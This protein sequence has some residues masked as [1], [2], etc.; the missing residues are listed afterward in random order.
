VTDWFT[1]SLRAAGVDPP[2]DRVI[3]GVGQLEWLGGEADA[4]AREGYVCWIGPEIYGVKWRN[5]KLVLVAQMCTLDAASK[6]PTPR[7]INLTTD[8][9]EREAVSPPYLHT[10]VATHFDRLIGA[11]EASTKREPAIP[12]GA[13]LEHVP[14]LPAN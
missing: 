2:S 14:T 5:V 12:R 6:L 11:F 8:P 3:D 4:S 10:S 7:L 13:P 9:Q 1:T